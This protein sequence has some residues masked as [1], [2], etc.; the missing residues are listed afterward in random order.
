MSDLAADTPDAGRVSDAERA[1]RWRLVLGGTGD[2][3][4]DGM[5]DGGL[6]A[7][8]LGGRD[9]RVDAALG[10]VYDRAPSGRGRSRAGGLGSSAPGVARWLGD[11][12][13]Y[14]P[15]PVVQVLQRDAVERLHL[16]QLLL[17]P[18]L[19]DA[20]EPDMHLVTLLVELQALLP[21][22]TRASARRVVDHVVR[23]I[24]RQFEARTVEAV[25][26]AVARSQRLRRPRP[27]DIDWNRTVQANLRHYMPELGTVVPERLVGHARRSRGLAREL[28]IAVDQSASMAD[29]VVYASVF[30]AVLAA[31][32]SVRTQMVAFDTSVVDLTPVLHD[33]VEVLFGVQLGGGTDIAAALSYCQRR[34][35]CPA[36][37]V[38]VLVSDLFEGGNESLL[39]RRVAELRRA[40][41]TVVVLLALADDGAPSYDH[42][43]A[44]ALAELGVASLACSPGAFPE[45]IAAAL[46][47]R[48]IGRWA[49]EHGLH[50][51]VPVD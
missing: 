23:E 41:V 27:A 33:P 48:H 35:T 18:E 28:V 16:Q 46:E 45:L 1:R 30:G 38:L 40:G 12:R 10:A 17:E 14:F 37:T 47:G 11:I 7:I 49:D 32:P 9:A 51:A 6:T 39:H 5:G 36:D 4:A 50:T 42:G 21:E 34:I 29:S 3:Q 15:T 2:D 31:L 22:A 8:G 13:R 24:R 43:Q 44:R 25:R 26:G 19:L 20:V